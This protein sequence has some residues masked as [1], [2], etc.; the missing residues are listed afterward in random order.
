[1]AG[2]A[3]SRGKTNE[4]CTGAK[5]RAWFPP[6]HGVNLRVLGDDAVKTQWQA[7]ANFMTT[8]EPRRGRKMRSERHWIYLEDEMPRIGSGMRYIEVKLGRKWAHVSSVN[9]NTKR[10]RV[11]LSTYQALSKGTKLF[12][13]RNQKT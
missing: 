9:D 13:K 6:D 4:D 8:P 7:S 2:G 1:M 10:Q 3:E 12:L 5:G 11:R